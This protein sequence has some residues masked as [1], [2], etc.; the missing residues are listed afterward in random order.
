MTSNILYIGQGKNVCKTDY[1]AEQKC[2][3]RNYMN[4]YHV[5]NGRIKLG[6]YVRLDCKKL[7]S[8]VPQFLRLYAVTPLSI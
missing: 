8:P 2:T 7:N 6:I 3:V 5:C 1:S 4:K